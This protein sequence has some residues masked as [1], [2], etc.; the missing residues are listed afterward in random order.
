MRHTPR[1]ASKIYKAP[2]MLEDPHFKAREAI[3][4]VPHPEFPNLWMQNVFPRLSDTPG[5]V[6]WPGPELGAHNREVYRDLAG[7]DDEDLAAL[8]EKGVI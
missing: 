2:D 5:G 3:V 7:L 1:A 8:M 4:R 6:A